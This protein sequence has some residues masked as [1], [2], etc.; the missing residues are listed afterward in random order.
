MRNFMWRALRDACANKFNL[1]RRRCVASPLCPICAENEE[2]MEHIILLCPWVTNVWKDGWLRIKI[3]R[4]SITTLADWV[5]TV[6]SQNLG[7]KEVFDK[8]IEYLAFSFWFIWRA[9]CDAVFNEL[10]PSTSRTTQIIFSALDSFKLASSSLQ[11]SPAT[12]GI[13]SRNVHCSVVW[14]PPPVNWVKVNVDACW[15]HD[16]HCGQVGIVV[17][18]CFSG[19]LAMSSVWVQASSVLMAEA[20]AVLEGCLLAKNLHVQEVVIKSDAQSIMRSLN[21]RALSCDWD[22][23]PILSRVLKVGR[24]FQSCSW[25][26]IPRSA[27]MTADFVARFIS[28]EM[29]G[30]SWVDRPP[31]SLVGILNKDEPLCPHS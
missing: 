12:R 25:S 30:F 20:I 14:S 31:S 3:N 11:G 23:L 21:A 7:N 18:D 16:S 24:S 15:N 26:W 6:G 13:I 8:T 17:R 2:T 27:N 29:C 19:C 1:F 28:S 4:S 5:C 10:K 22:L 9:R